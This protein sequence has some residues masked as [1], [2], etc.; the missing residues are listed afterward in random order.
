MLTLTQAV[1]AFPF[2]LAVSW[3]KRIDVDYTDNGLVFKVVVD[4]VIKY[5]GPY[6]IDAI[7]AYNE[8]TL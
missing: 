2:H 1:G 7:N 8:A 6:I 4:S 3:L 5:N